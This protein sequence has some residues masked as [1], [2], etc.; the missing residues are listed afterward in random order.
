MA[1]MQV[2]QSNAT[3]NVKGGSSSQLD[4]CFGLWAN[5]SVSP[6]EATIETAKKR[7]TELQWSLDEIYEQATSFSISHLTNVI[8]RQEVRDYRRFWKVWPRLY[9]VT[10]IRIA[11]GAKMELAST[12]R[13]EKKL[14]VGINLDQQTGTRVGFKGER[15]RLKNYHNA[16][17]KATDFVFAYQCQKISTFCGPRI[18]T[19]RGDT[20]NATT[21]FATEKGDPE[22]DIRLFDRQPKKKFGEIEGDVDSNEVLSGSSIGPEYTGLNVIL[23]LEGDDGKEQWLRL[24]THEYTVLGALILSVS[25]AAFWL[26]GYY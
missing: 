4:A 5:F 26:G 18:D 19:V 13:N 2:A 20:L 10:G 16:F 21:G 14:R 9:I 7:Q 12:P 3:N 17:E 24:I 25:L 1:G 15:T 8:S 23:Q 11:R 22:A 6:G